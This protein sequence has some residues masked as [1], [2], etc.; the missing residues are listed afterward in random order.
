MEVKSVQYSQQSQNTANDSNMIKSRQ[1]KSLAIVTF[2]RLREF[3]D[4][5]R[6]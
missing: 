4:A 3:E 2:E 5:A 1:T 6:K